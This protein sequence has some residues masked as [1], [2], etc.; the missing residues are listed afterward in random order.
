MK[1]STKLILR[2]ILASLILGGSVLLHNGQMNNLF[3]KTT[4]NKFDIKND[5]LEDILDNTDSFKIEKQIFSLKKHYYVLVDDVIVAEITGKFFPIF[6]DTLEMVDANGKL[7]KVE[8]QVKRLGPTKDKLFNFS[9]DRLAKIQ[10]RD[11]NTTGYIGE[12]KIKDFFKLSHRQHFFDKNGNKIGKGKQDF[13]FSKDLTV[14]DMNDNIDYIIDGNILSFSSKATIT[15]KDNTEINEED[16]IFY[17]IIEDSITNG[18]S[19][20]SKKK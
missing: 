9:I 16:V 5:S 20:S 8:H 15:K 13:I 17:N 19:S 7:V 10:D 6:G 11:G 14:S 1:F 4:S 2:T 18:S 3:D 12:E